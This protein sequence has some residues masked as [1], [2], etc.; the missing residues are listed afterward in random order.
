MAWRLMSEE[1]FQCSIC[2]D[3]FVNP[4]TISCGHTFCQ[5]CVTQYWDSTAVCHCPLCKR[6][7]IRRPQVN[8]NTTMRDLVNEFKSM[9]GPNSG[10]ALPGE[11]TCDMCSGDGQGRLRALKTCLD[12]GTSLCSVHLELHQRVPRLQRH[13]LT[14]PLENPEERMC[15]R[16]QR[17]L[18]LFCRDDHVCVCEFC[19]EG[20]HKSHNMVPLEEEGNDRKN[21]MG[22]SRVELQQMMKERQGKITEIQ[23]NMEITKTSKKEE[24]AHFGELF[25]S[26][27]AI[28]ERSRCDLQGA[29]ETEQRTMETQAEKLIRQLQQQIDTL[30][31][32]DTQLEEL[33]HTH[34]HFHL[35][36]ADLSLC[37]TP[38]ITTTDV[39]VKD[40]PLNTDPY[41]HE[42][43]QSIKTEI[44]KYT[45]NK[46]WWMQCFAVD[47]TLDPDTA[48]PLLR[49]S[50]DQKQVRCGDHLQN[51]PDLPV[52][53]DE[54]KCVL[55]KQ[56]FLDRFYFQVKV[57]EKSSWSIGVTSESVSR[58][59]RVKAGPTTGYWTI[60]LRAGNQYLAGT[61]PPRPLFVENKP[62]MLGVFVD[63]DMGLVSFY[64]VEMESHLFSFTEQMFSGKLFPVLSPG[65]NEA[66]TNLKPIIISPLSQQAHM[67][68]FLQGLG[69]AA[70]C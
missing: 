57:A 23:R 22:E 19:T 37:Q 31:S 64:D 28:L 3:V 34:D 25:S 1:Q 36:Q 11:V 35:V 65:V 44:I 21:Q 51:V 4:V 58:K 16:H 29:L 52:R 62:Q 24:L 66:G 26:L 38:N 17:P 15:Q 54:S 56:G 63:Y 10:V 46:L 33:I 45:W 50:E 12:C 68:A 61:S 41:L 30:Q 43:E 48:H 5:T 32:R 60:V 18:K 69:A 55:G 13:T 9:R 70:R 7:F 14:E 47:V 42:L 6:T 8:I 39:R 27:E 2:L 20:E 53:F 67:L 59:G 40:I 49:L